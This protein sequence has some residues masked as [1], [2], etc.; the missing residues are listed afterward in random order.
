M[1]ALPDDEA[2]RERIREGVLRGCY[3][4]APPPEAA[5]A[6]G[7]GSGRGRRGRRR[8]RRRNRRPARAKAFGRKRAGRQAPQQEGNTPA[9]GGTPHATILFSGTTWQVAMEAREAASLGNGTSAPNAGPV[10]SYK[11]LPGGRPSEVERWNASTPSSAQT[12]GVL[13]AG[14]SLRPTGPSLP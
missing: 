2:E 6:V 10:T 9:E 8:R 4:F 11:S 13:F 12:G 14:H 7:E 1:P 5:N 3:L